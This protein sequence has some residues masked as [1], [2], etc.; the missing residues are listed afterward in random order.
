MPPIDGLQL[1]A[2]SVSRLCVSSSVFAPCARCGK[3]SFG[4]GMAAA[5]NNDIETGGKRKI[6]GFYPEALMQQVARSA[7]SKARSPEHIAAHD[8][9]K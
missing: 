2:P 1:I 3:R 9:L 8:D 4:A 5:D 6:T 7:S